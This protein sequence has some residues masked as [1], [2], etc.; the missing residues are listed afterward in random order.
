MAYKYIRARAKK[1]FFGVSATVT[2][3]PNGVTKKG[4]PKDRPDLQA[5]ETLL[6]RP[7]KIKYIPLQA[8]VLVEMWVKGSNGKLST[9]VHFYKDTNYE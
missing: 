1:G 5:F 2:I 7:L 8:N 3:Q 6:N 4:L 9:Q